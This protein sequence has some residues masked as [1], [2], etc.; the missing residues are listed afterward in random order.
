MNKNET[1]TI[2]DTSLR[3]GA[4]TEGISFSAIAKIKLARQLDAF[5]IDYIEGGYA[6]S[7]E[8]DMEFF[9]QI[10]K[11]KLTHAKIVAF[12]ATRRAHT[13]VRNDQYLASL[14]EA[15][16][17]AV[18]LVGK[19]SDFH[20]SEVL[21]TTEREN[22]AM[23]SDSIEF[24]KDHRKEVFLDAE[25]FFDGYKRNPEYSMKVLQA[26][27]KAGSNGIVLCDTNGG[28]LPEEIFNITRAVVAAVT[29]PVGIHVHNDMGLAVANT[30]EAVRAG[31]RQVQGTIN[32]LGERCGNADLCSV[33]PALLLKM[34]Y[35]SHKIAH[36]RDLRELSLLLDDLAN[37]RHNPRS[38]Y[39]GQ[40]AFAHK[41]GPHVNA[42]NKNPRSF[43]HITPAAVGN[44]RRVL[45]SE[46]SGSSNVLLKAIELGVG[47]EKSVKEA[48]GILHA[49][50]SLEAKG[51]AYEA[52]DASFRM[53]IQKVLK[54]HKSFFE[55]EG[56]RVIVEKR[57]KNE[58]CL[59]EATIKVRVNDEIEQT[60]AEGD[61][62]VN[63]LDGA[64]RK[65][66]LRFYPQIAKVFL[67]DFRVNILDPEES[68]AAKTRVL[69]ES[70]DGEDSWGTVGVS[71]NIIEAS[72]EALV[73]SVEYKLF[74]E[75][76]KKRKKRSVKKRR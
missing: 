10:R 32:G 40:S 14:I 72:W 2:Y 11:E 73:D 57:G 5:G 58:P 60:A 26:A 30:L 16:T 49:M 37:Q 33:V 76:E 25:H 67:T 13:K 70:S 15:A 65:A 56:F 22:L 75:E 71:G 51:Y 34:G 44:S 45:V 38:P 64:L 55:L 29:V 53:L 74:R 3:D 18:T 66:L 6:G 35:S 68:T 50:K 27:V 12:G 59:S 24:L 31:A 7:N 47:R 63:A 20:V 69:I 19:A 8:K 42:V 28:C 62:P 39:V 43:E 21:R 1:I 48:R 61:G 54:E 36:L 52:A 9:R 46:L 41:A 17:P 23:I 4:Q